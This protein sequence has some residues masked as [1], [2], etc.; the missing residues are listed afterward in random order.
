M[1]D[2]NYNDD[3]DDDYYYYY[4]YSRVYIMVNT[5][6]NHP[7]TKNPWLLISG[8]FPNDLG[9]PPLKIKDELE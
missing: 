8:A 3:D 1:T 2:N 7:Q 9:I 6:S 4:D 5:Q